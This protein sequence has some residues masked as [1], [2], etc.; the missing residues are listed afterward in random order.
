MWV[1]PGPFD[2]VPVNCFITSVVPS[3]V[4]PSPSPGFAASTAALESVVPA[5]TR[6]V[7]G[8]P[9]HVGDARIDAPQHGSAGTHR[10]ES[11]CPA[12]LV[13]DTGPCVLLQIP[14]EAQIVPFFPPAPVLQEPAVDPVGL[15]PQQ[16][17]VGSASS[18]ASARPGCRCCWLRGCCSA[19]ACR[20]WACS[21]QA[22]E[23]SSAGPRG[24]P[25]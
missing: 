11:G 10:G 22:S 8:S 24:S 4:M 16:I 17:Q 21:G 5:T 15:V 23:Y 7:R 1:I 6:S 20:R 9:E 25:S 12:L 19:P 14:A 2:R 13:D 18:S 3:T